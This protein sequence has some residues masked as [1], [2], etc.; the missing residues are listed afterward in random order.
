MQREHW[1]YI[2]LAVLVLAFVWAWRVARE[3]R[4]RARLKR[5]MSGVSASRV[6]SARTR[7]GSL[8]SDMRW[9]ESKSEVME[10]LAKTAT[11]PPS[12]SAANTHTRRKRKAA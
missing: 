7:G 8:R 3:R 2:A 6:S 5:K 9:A 4:R 1:L 10:Q 11:N 12:G